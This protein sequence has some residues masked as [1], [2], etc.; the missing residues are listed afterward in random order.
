MLGANK[1][2]EL[3]Q[4]ECEETIRNY[5]RLIKVSKIRDIKSELTSTLMAD[6]NAR[7]NSYGVYIEKVNVM[8]VVIPR[9]LR[10]A[11]QT[12]TTYDV[13][14]QQQVK[15]QEYTIIRMINENDK[16]M[17]ILKRANQMKMNELSHQL[18]MEEI[19][20]EKIKVSTETEQNVAIIKGQ[21]RL[22]IRVIQAEAIKAQAERRA[23]KEAERI[24]GEAKAY[25]EAKLAEANAA[26]E[27]L[28]FKAEVRLEA[29]KLRSQGV[30][31][32]A[33]AET[34][35]AANLD[36]KRKFE[37]K[38]LMAENMSKMIATNKI[39]LSGDNAEQVLGFFKD[40]N[41]MVN[42]NVNE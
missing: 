30:L 9:D 12:A 1:L 7:F 2:E 19:A 8:N 10:Y 24:L 18:A 32:E 31:Q 11:L 5:I 37:Q 29:A 33:E 16:A 21:E 20:L 28:K 40:T 17:L 13:L 25:S 34:V 3:L 6:L 23:K 39:I 26:K 35:H 27:G 4:Q 14:L 38:I 36:P 22:S 42:L 41:D 15:F